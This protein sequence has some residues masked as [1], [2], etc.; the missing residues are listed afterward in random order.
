[1][2]VV[3]YAR[4]M[5]RFNPDALSLRIS[6]LIADHLSQAKLA[7]NAI[8]DE[9]FHQNAHGGSR[10]E[11]AVFHAVRDE[12]EN[13]VR[14]SLREL[15]SYPAARRRRQDVRTHE[16]L[17]NALADF[18]ELALPEDVRAFADRYPNAMRGEGQSFEEKLEMYW[19]EYQ[20][21]L[22]FGASTADLVLPWYQRPFGFTVLAILAGLTVTALA[23]VL[24]WN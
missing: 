8:R 22:R 9:A 11:I 20:G 23:A 2:P 14:A 15:Q 13:L 6:R 24:G 12:F 5:Q 7:A 4:P 18:R 10:E 16:L 19:M 1:M 21:G 17:T 3:G